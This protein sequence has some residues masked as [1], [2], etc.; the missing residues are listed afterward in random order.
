MLEMSLTTSEKKNSIM[1]WPGKNRRSQQGGIWE[2]GLNFCIFFAGLFA[3][4][5]AG[6]SPAS[7]SPA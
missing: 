4:Y 7:F 5:F 6:L 2:S 3:G 1:I